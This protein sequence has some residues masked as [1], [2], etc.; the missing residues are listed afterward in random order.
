MQPTK[1]EKAVVRINTHQGPDP[2][3][4]TDEPAA[5]C[6]DHAPMAEK[7]QQSTRNVVDEA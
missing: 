5:S 3:A 7:R 4:K 2:N 1:S 6:T